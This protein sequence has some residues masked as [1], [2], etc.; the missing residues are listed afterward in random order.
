MSRN[1]VAT[2]P[3]SEDRQQLRS[4]RSLRALA[5]VPAVGMLVAG[6][7][8]ACGS[9]ASAGQSSSSGAVVPLVVYSAQGYDS[10][11]T[12]AFQKATGIPVQLDDDSTGPLLTKVAAEKNNPKWG[13]LWVDGNTAFAALD[14]QG[15]L[16]DYASPVPLNAAGQSLVPADHSYIPVS[17]TVMAALIYNA[18]K[19]NAVPST[20]QDL[21]GSQYR[22]LV[23]MNDP[24]QSG[25]TFPFIAG[26][27]NQLG[28]TSNGVSAGEAY[29]TQL[30]ANGLHVFPTNG[31]TLHA[32]ETG[33]IDYGLI[34]SSAATGEVVKQPATAN[35]QPK[36]VYLPKPTL[37]P[38]V[39][40]IDKAAPA[41]VQAEAE[42][43]VQYVLSPAGQTVMQG[44]DPSGDS[45]YW[46]VVPG[47]SPVVAL[48]AFPSSYQS[49]DPTF[50][51]PL[52]GQVNSWFDS[53]IK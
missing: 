29:L 51:G 14:Q 36:V 31:D 21:L 1:M 35:F 12:K 16:L 33:Q 30:K 23:G 15:Q 43:F 39:I 24:S 3:G 52:E 46:P 26:L 10:A 2:A 18:A 13:L 50:W 20:Y 44:G 4:G 38:G 45:L 34:Q 40:G 32:L 8:A 28:G 22:G 49:I 5:V 42:K 9:A 48:P 37:L 47:I 25:P 41:N 53:N 6:S 27:M 17:T 19:V 7:L 11:V